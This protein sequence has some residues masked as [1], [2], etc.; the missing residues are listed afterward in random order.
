MNDKINIAIAEDHRLVRQGFIRML[1]DYPNIN[2]LFEASN[3][4]EL[5]KSLKEHKPSIILLDIAMPIIGGIKA[6]NIIRERHPKLKIIVISS[7]AEE[8]S[9]IEYVKLGAN[10]FLNKDCDVEELVKA[11]Y[12][13]NENGTHFDANTTKLLTKH[14]ILPGYKNQRGLTEREITVLQFICNNKPYEEIA[15]IMGLKL[16]TVN[17]YEYQLFQ[18]TNCKDLNSLIVYAKTNLLI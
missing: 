1:S 13:L 11:I 14:G 10:S 15:E 17:W 9:I 8:T 4:K 6:M 3:G 7:Y 2:I 5:L 16:R 12:S 18:K